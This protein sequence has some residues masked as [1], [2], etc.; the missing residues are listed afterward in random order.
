VADNNKNIVQAFEIGDPDMVV[1]NI[2]Q[3]AI[4]GAA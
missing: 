3:A 2:G 4:V 1:V